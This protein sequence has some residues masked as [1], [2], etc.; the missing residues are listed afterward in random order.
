MA[1]KDFFISYTG[2]DEQWATW[3]AGTLEN[4]GYKTIIQAWDFN[5]S[6]DF[7]AQMQNALI[8][9][10]RFIPVLSKAYL[11]KT[12]W[13][14]R[15]W[16][17]ALAKDNSLEKGLFIPVWIEYINPET[18]DIGLFATINAILLYGKKEEQEAEKEL[19]DGV[20]TENQTAQEIVR[21]FQELKNQ[22]IL[23]N[24]LLI[25]FLSNKTHTSQGEMIY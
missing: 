10:E 6:Q 4:S 7:V 19:L 25:I 11:S 14:Q 1:K 16:T 21:H 9:C 15:E 23:A 3:I 5:K 12:G 20:S 22:V 17:S 2:K 18:D 13:C 24:Y 8:N